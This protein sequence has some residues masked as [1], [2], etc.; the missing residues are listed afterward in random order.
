MFSVSRVLV[1]GIA[2][3]AAGC[4]PTS[5]PEPP[6]PASVSNGV[7]AANSDGSRSPSEQLVALH[8]AEV[9]VLESLT[10]PR[11]FV[12]AYGY[13]RSDDTPHTAPCPTLGLARFD[14]DG[15][16]ISHEDIDE[17]CVASVE[18]FGLHDLSPRASADLVL[19]AAFEVAGTRR[20][21]SQGITETSS[22]LHIYTTEGPAL[23]SLAAIEFDEEFE[24]GDCPY[25]RRRVLVKG[26]DHA[27]ELYE[28]NWNRCAE[29]DYPVDRLRAEWDDAD[30]WRQPEYE[31]WEGTR[32]PPSSLR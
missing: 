11:G 10:L 26:P 19:I 12:V 29:K 15:A 17:R 16:L 25:G 6:V 4:R 7:E 14:D 27:L 3:G 9:R 24:N 18:H 28:Q 20:D 30:G 23:R 1:A 8:Q 22:D 31:D 21:G 5:S 13:G 32:M 2:C